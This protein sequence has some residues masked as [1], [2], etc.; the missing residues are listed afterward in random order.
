MILSIFT[1]F[2][3]YRSTGVAQAKM[4][5]YKLNFTKLALDK[6]KL[7][8]SGKRVYIYDTKESGLVLDVTP[9]GK[10]TYYLYK[11]VEGRPQRI[12]IGDYLDISIENARKKATALK[13]K[14]ND[15]CNPNEEKRNIRQEI[16][17]GEMFDKFLNDYSKIHKKSWEED[18]GTIKRYLEKYKLRRMSEIDSKLISKIHNDIAHTFTERDKKADR[19]APKF[20]AANR[21]L[22][23]LKVVFNKAIEWGWDGK[24]PCDNVKAYKEKSRDRFLQPD[25]IKRFFSAVE[26][27][28]NQTIRDYV[29]I[30]LLTGARK[31]NVLSMRW[32]EISFKTAQWRI[33]ETKNGEPLTIPLVDE[34]I[35]ILKNRKKEIEDSS[36][37]VFPGKSGIS[38]LKDPKK[39]WK[40][41]L[42]KAGIKDFRIHDLRRT[43]GSYQAIIGA[44]SYVIGKSLGHKSHAATQIYARLNLDPVRESME[45]ATGKMIELSKNDDRSDN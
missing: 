2:H 31:S 13:S 41:I 43:M 10:K 25:E 16:T 35:K 8:V 14:I 23:F 5:S 33:P 21:T 12:K 18:E 1:V 40:R 42:A 29:Y 6:V 22:E 27:E 32:N 9:S 20:Y 34:A 19:T 3:V 28:G 4:A 24:N 39:G 45:K 36:E 38:Y 30:S 11:R 7:P 44:N 15:G 17:L 26:N 37:Y